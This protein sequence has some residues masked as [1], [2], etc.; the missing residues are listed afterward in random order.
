M[1]SVRQR[2]LRSLALCFVAWT[3]LALFYF[4]QALIQKYLSRDPSPWWHYL[5]AWLTGAYISAALTP[6]VLWL[7]L[8]FPFRRTNWMRIAGLHLALSLAFSSIQL[9]VE[10]FV[11]FRFGV[12]PSVLK[13]FATAL[14]FLSVIGFHQNILTYWLILGL[15][16]AFRYYRDYQRR[17]RDALEL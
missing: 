2:W 8:R 5:V 10:A 14:V 3:F 7:G 4:S 11:L 1:G 17:E 15:Q 12:F 6:L 13:S 16:R 9:V